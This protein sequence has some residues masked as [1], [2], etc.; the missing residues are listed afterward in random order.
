MGSTYLLV[1]IHWI[2]VA[3]RWLIGDFRLW[4]V[5]FA[6]SNAWL[7]WPLHCA[8]HVSLTF[9]D[10]WSRW[11]AQLLHAPVE[12]TVSLVWH[13]WHA[14][15]TYGERVGRGGLSWLSV[16]DGSP[17]DTLNSPL[18]CCGCSSRAARGVLGLDGGPPSESVRE[19]RFEGTSVRSITMS[20][21]F[22]FDA[23]TL[24]SKLTAPNTSILRWIWHVSLDGKGIMFTPDNGA[25]Y[26]GDWK[27]GKRHGIVSAA[28][29]SDT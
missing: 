10:L 4:H 27:D 29:R 7:E 6:W 16:L 12:V 19:S 18:W 24:P 11:T 15:S 8:W 28:E 2:F 20:S 13:F 1:I 22:T 23:T 25:K 17:P 26:E 14:T 3:N 21:G 9:L 5:L